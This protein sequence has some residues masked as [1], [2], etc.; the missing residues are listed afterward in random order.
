MCACSPR[1]SVST[2]AFLR[3]VWEQTPHVI[4]TTAS[5]AAVLARG[6]SFFDRTAIDGYRCSGDGW[7]PASSTTLLPY[8]SFATRR[9]ATAVSPHRASFHLSFGYLTTVP[10]SVVRPLRSRRTWVLW[11]RPASRR[12]ALHATKIRSVVLAWVYPIHACASGVHY[13]SAVTRAGAADMG[14]RGSVS[15]RPWVRGVN[16]S[17]MLLTQYHR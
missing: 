6:P 3:L 17:S 9:A 1:R 10:I 14:L 4:A 5:T 12:P 7:T 16:V 11:P 2:S 13:A 15:G 8:R